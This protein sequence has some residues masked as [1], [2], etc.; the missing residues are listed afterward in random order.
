MWQTLT[1][2]IRKTRGRP[3]RCPQMVL[4]SAAALTL[5]VTYVGMAPTQFSPQ[6]VHAADPAD[7]VTLR[8]RFQYQ[9]DPY[10]D[11][12]IIA[13]KS[14]SGPIGASV[15]SWLPDGYTTENGDYSV[16]YTLTAGANTVDVMMLA[17][18]VNVT[19]KVID[20]RGKVTF[21]YVTTAGTVVGTDTISGKP[22]ATVSSAVPIRY[23]LASGSGTV[24]T[25]VAPADGSDTTV[26]I[27]VMLDPNY[28]TQAE[29]S[30]TINFVDQ[31]T[32]SSQTVIITGKAGSSV[33]VHYPNE[34]GD[35]DYLP[36]TFVYTF[37]NAA[38]GQG[39][40]VPA[41]PM[42]VALYTFYTVNNRGAQTPVY[43]I[44]YMG[45]PGALIAPTDMF[46]DQENINTAGGVKGSGPLAGYIRTD[47]PF[48]LTNLPSTTITT[49]STD[50]VNVQVTNVVA[51]GIW[52][53]CRWYI[54]TSNVLHI[55][56]GTGADSIGESPWRIY[57]NAITQIS[58]DGHVILPAN[59]RF[60][61]GTDA[62]G[63]NAGNYQR[64]TQVKG[65]ANVDASQVQDLTAMFQLDSKMKTITGL[66]D[67]NVQNV[68]W[69]SSMFARTTAL[70]NLGDLSQWDTAAAKAMDG[71]F[72]ACAVQ[73]PGDLS[74]WET[75]NVI[76]MSFMFYNTTKLNS[77]GD[78][79]NWNTSQVTTMSHMFA[80][81]ALKTPGH[82]DDWNTGN[83]T[84][85]DYLFAQTSTLN[86]IGDLSGWDTSKATDMS[87][88]FDET[89]ALT[90]IGDLDNWDTHNVT[91]MLAMF[92][93]TQLRNIGS[94]AKWNTTNLTTTQNMFT[95]AVNLAVLDFTNWDTSKVT[96]FTSMFE[97]MDALRQITFGPRFNI[98]P[99][100]PNATTTRSWVSV[101]GGTL[102]APQG[103]T[104]LTTVQGN[105][106]TSTY[107]GRNAAT[108][109][110]YSRQAS[111]TI[112]Y[113]DENNVQV[114]DSVTLTGNIGDTLTY[115]P[116]LPVGYDFADPNDAKQKAITITNTDSDNVLIKVEKWASQFPEAGSSSGLI[117]S[118]VGGFT[119]LV[120][121]IGLIFS[122][123]RKRD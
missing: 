62:V 99:D 5:G 8:V 44:K 107:T 102:D 71:M 89:A 108:Y 43:K 17:E 46:Y 48:S 59:C 18:S 119:L 101:D 50:N 106:V 12:R 49:D 72:S 121:L 39:T 27:P 109:V 120:G 41:W 77:V 45:R 57:S 66:D 63:K 87:Y 111:A 40:T 80:F 85:M 104:D 103:L 92:R 100:V 21:N 64:L 76:D 82:L 84:A 58:I 78:L 16:A 13:T 3:Q 74:G 38:N 28:T 93:V 67:W 96:N 65:L 35:A 123:R 117:L 1:N 26:T 55:G 112:T 110:L 34:L 2:S 83:V 86:D 61:F 68:N 73:N 30:A 113:Q 118:I 75:G 9:S 22:G 31:L 42:Q 29:M 81:T 54:D 88:M 105:T 95:R 56:P 116:Q 7:R 24:A 91:T 97:D 23:M 25:A 115:T 53:T 47:D 37:T 69:F 14:Y 36:A 60:L 15:T 32:G 10:D 19:T 90:D 79:G 51:K 4:L 11:P 114:G 122:V 70:S 33:T 98:T 52:G 20:S 6:I 94:L